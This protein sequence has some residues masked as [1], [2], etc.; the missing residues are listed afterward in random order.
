SAAQARSRRRRRINIWLGHSLRQS[1]LARPGAVTG[2]P[3]VLSS[4]QHP[5]L[6]PLGRATTLTADRKSTRLN[7]SHSPISYAFF[8]LKKKTHAMP[9]NPANHTATRAN[10]G[11]ETRLTT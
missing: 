4:K 10:Q 5:V 6:E 2:A 7:P 11:P 8:C 9:V 1:A 3:M